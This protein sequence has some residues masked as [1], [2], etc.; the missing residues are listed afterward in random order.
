MRIFVAGAA[1]AIGRHLTPMLVAAGH[2][3]AGTTRSRERAAWLEAM[4]ATPAIVDAL[5]ADRLRC[6]VSE[7][8]PEV[9][10]HQLTDLSRGF[11][12]ESLVGNARLRATGTAILVRAAIAAG[13]RRL[14]AQS[15]AWLYADG[16]EPHVESDPLRSPESYPDDVTLP[17]VIELERVVTTAQPLEG[18]V[19][20]YGF[21]YGPGTNAH[22]ETAPQPRVDVRAAARAALRAV[23]RGPSGVYNIVDD[24]GP[25]SS[26]RA[27]E[28]LGWR[29]VA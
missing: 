19:L 8:R 1:G 24:G 29:P 15:A 13:A 21:L 16:P 27:N 25:V 2:S 14:V 12:T 23:D 5:E 17:S 3:V 26:R 6:A 10:I 22:R 28:L 4:G 18:V 9:V 11:D 7:A 20:R